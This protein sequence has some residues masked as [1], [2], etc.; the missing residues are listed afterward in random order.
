M[1]IYNLWCHVV[2]FLYRWQD[3]AGALIGG[4]LGV[5]GAFIVA[6]RFQ[7]AEFKGAAIQIT[8][9]LEGVIAVA[10]RYCEKQKEGAPRAV[11]VGA[12]IG[13]SLLAT[14]ALFA[15]SKQKINMLAEYLL[16]EH[17]AIFE[18]NYSK[19]LERLETYSALAPTGIAAHVNIEKEIENFL[20][21]SGYNAIC[22]Q[23]LINKKVLRKNFKRNP[24]LENT[25]KETIGKI[26]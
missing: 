9:E 15:Q 10:R 7:A 6:Q 5:V 1:A 13:S 21:S 17:L 8:I 18:L 22:I 23:Y 11:L 14:T 3:L 20:L 4:L 25:V 16:S 24:D 19:L 12:V 2:A 26:E